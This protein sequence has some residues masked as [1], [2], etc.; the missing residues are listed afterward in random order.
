MNDNAADAFNLDK[1]LGFSLYRTQILYSAVMRR[2]IQA[3]GRELTPEQLNLLGRLHAQEGITQSQLGE[4]AYKD[5]HNTARILNL[6]EERGLVERRPDQ[7][8]RRI[9]RL[10]LTRNGRQAYEELLPLLREHFKNAFKG[11]SPAELAEGLR[12]LNLIFANLEELS[13]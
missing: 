4:L 5:R 1:T 6:L 13:Q 10:Y 8:D 7:S 3:T 12:V 2:A 9:Y 11:L